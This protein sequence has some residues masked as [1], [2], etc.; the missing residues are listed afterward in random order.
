MKRVEYK[1]ALEHMECEEGRKDAG[2]QH[3]GE[4]K[5]KEVQ[6]ECWPELT[7][8]NFLRRSPRATV[9]ISHVDPRVGS[10]PRARCAGSFRR[11]A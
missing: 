4:G 7:G 6:A 2:H 8:H 1:E 11:P 5:L 9:Q 3:D 10:G